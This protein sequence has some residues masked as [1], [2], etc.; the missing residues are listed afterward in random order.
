MDQQTKYMLLNHGSTGLGFGVGTEQ[1]FEALDM[2]SV[3]PVNWAAFAGQAA[4]GL[5][6]LVL[7]YMAWRQPKINVSV[8][9]VSQTGVK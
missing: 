4:K 7:G 2:L 1:V 8:T 9:D 6:I 3:V 5:L